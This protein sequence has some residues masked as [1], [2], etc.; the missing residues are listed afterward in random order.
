[1]DQRSRLLYRHA[2]GGRLALARKSRGMGQ[3][4]LADQIGVSKSV[5]S[6]WERGIS[7]P[8]ADTLGILGDA[9][10][11]SVE[12]IIGTP[13]G[14]DRVCLIDTQAEGLLLAA[15][16]VDRE[17]Q[18]RQARLATIAHVASERVATVEALG[19]RVARVMDRRRELEHSTDDEHQAPR[20]RGG[21]RR[22]SPR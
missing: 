21:V 13:S 3:Q 10:R 22:S 20:D 2:I 9:L 18:V 14:E 16:R 7:C 6:N 17:F 4:E 5:V 15:D 11:C 19:E 8:P 12:W 1:M